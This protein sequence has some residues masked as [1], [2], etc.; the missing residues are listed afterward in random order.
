MG[1][2]TG[3]DN[4]HDLNGNTNYQ[5]VEAQALPTKQNERL[6]W[7]LAIILGALAGFGGIL[8]A[9]WVPALYVDGQANAQYPGAGAG[10]TLGAMFLGTPL[11]AVLGPIV[12][13]IGGLIGGLLGS[14]LDRLF[15]RKSPFLIWLL[16]AIGGLFAGLVA[17]VIAILLFF[18]EVG[19]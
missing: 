15:G 10:A 5:P 4:A 9:I 8:L 19:S 2:N 13:I 3:S 7:I 6:N 16:G 17:G 14:L 11:A 1:M 12:G 18:R